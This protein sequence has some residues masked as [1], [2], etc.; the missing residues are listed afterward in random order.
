M[1]EELQLETQII[2]E[3]WAKPEKKLKISE[4]NVEWKKFGIWKKNME[5]AHNAIERMNL[6]NKKKTL[7]NVGKKTIIMNT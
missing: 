5:M 2:M 7:M 6:N 1:Q 3:K 4:L